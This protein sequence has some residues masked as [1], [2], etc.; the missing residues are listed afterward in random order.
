M[1]YI[2]LIC[3]LFCGLPTL[4]QPMMLRQDTTAQWIGG[5]NSPQ[6]QMMDLNT[7]GRQDLVIFDRTNSKFYT[8]LSLPT[9]RQGAYS[10]QY[11]PAYERVFP[12]TQGWF[13]LRDY[14]QDGLKD[15]FAHAPNGM[16]GWT[17][18]KTPQGIFFKQFQEDCIYTK[19]LSGKINLQI[20]IT[21][22]P[23]LHD[24]NGDGMLDVV[25]FDFA[26]GSYLELHLNTSKDKNVLKLERQGYC[27]GNLWEGVNCGELKLD[28]PCEG[29]GESPLTPEGGKPYLHTG[30]TITIADLNQDK[31]LD[32]LVG[33]ISCKRLYAI[34]NKGTNLKPIFAKI[35][36]LFP[37]KKPVNLSIFPASFVEDVNFDGLPDLLVAP[38]VFRNEEN[39]IDFQHS[40]WYY[41]G[42]KKGRKFEYQFQ[43][44][45]FLQEKMLDV[46]ENAAPLLWD[47]DQD[48]DYD[49]IVGNR[50]LRGEGS[51]QPQRG[52]GEFRGTL[53]L[54]ENVGT[55]QKPDFQLKDKDFWKLSAEKMTDIKPFLADT[56]QDGRQEFHILA[57]QN[58]ERVWLYRQDH[59][60]HW[61]KFPYK[62]GRQEFPVFVDF[63]AD[64]DLD[65]LISL[66]QNEWRYIENRAGEGLIEKKAMI[67][68][69]TQ[70]YAFAEKHP[71]IADMNGDGQLD[72]IIEKQGNI[73]LYSE[74]IA[75]WQAGKLWLGDENI[76]YNQTLNLPTQYDVGTF[77]YPT[78][79]D[80][81]GDGRLDMMTG[82]GTGGVA[83]FWNKVE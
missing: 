25:T 82:L 14:N 43:T 81:D 26:Q 4:A 13:L 64:K 77:S 16:Q 83:L 9:G 62:L 23:C 1:K 76:V 48:G 39:A 28:Y 34:Y 41:V 66:P 30:S 7:D 2:F 32:L 73:V 20:A 22:I 38:N 72:L 61:Q 59:T 49:L 53:H 42:K 29:G 33:D 71:L 50:G 78:A 46:G 11:A 10:W 3:F 44:N 27:W 8:F 17:A 65:I 54:F 21:D 60:Q 18:E 80:L 37:K 67:R 57:Y 51:P 15:F 47:Y 5:L 12:K 55:K 75:Q 36:T 63:D 56:D 40:L 70:G 24:I 52:E 45:A 69:P 31:L 74:A 19:G 79:A 58:R 68:L 35:D 6:V